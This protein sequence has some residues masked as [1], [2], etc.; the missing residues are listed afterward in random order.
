MRV[1]WTRRALLRV[2]EAA[3]YIARERPGAATKW[4]AGIREAVER[5]A[6]YPRS[7]RVAEDLGREDVREIFHGGYRV[8][9]R[10]EPDRVTILSVRHQRQ[11]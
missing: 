2:E 6:E 3:A 11:G 5:L 9:Y 7:G 1:Q 8:V 10:V 4:L